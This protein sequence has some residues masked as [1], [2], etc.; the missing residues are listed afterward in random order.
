MTRW[1]HFEGVAMNARF[2]LCTI[3]LLVLALLILSISS[4][5]QRVVAET[6]YYVTYHPSANNAT[7][8]Y[9]YGKIQYGPVPSSDIYFADDGYYEAIYT[10]YSGVVYTL[11]SND[12]NRENWYD[13][14]IDGYVGYLPPDGA[15]ITSVWV[16]AKFLSW[17]PETTLHYTIDGGNNWNMSSTW[18]AG[19]YYVTLTWNVTSLETWTPLLVNNT[20]FKVKCTMYPAASIAYF[21]DYI[22]IRV[23][24]NIDEED[25]E[26]SE[27][28][29]DDPETGD[30]GWD[31]SY[32]FIMDNGGIIGMMGVIGFI[33]LI[34]IPAGAIVI[35][36]SSHG[37]GKI[38][39]FV[40]TLVAWMF[41]LTLVLL[42]V[43]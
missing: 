11:I 3:M 37:E 38:G 6:N 42:A 23:H 41:C 7:Y 22:G 20:D 8:Q 21:V 18:G 10:S 43:S 28:P 9:N 13:P 16:I 1:C 30:G 12:F 39:T 2:R 24:W 34:A 27:D 31:F 17:N 19:A 35:Y 32:E 36:R 5:S 14:E 33:G 26:G 15:N 25:G 29:Q 40:K 4:I